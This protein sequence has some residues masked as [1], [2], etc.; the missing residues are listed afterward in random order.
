MP[1]P[2]PADFLLSSYSFELPETSIAQQPAAERG[3]SRLLVIDKATGATRHSHFSHIAEFLP[4]RALLVANNTRV[5]PARVLGKRPLTAHGG[6]GKIE[7]L[8]LTPPVLVEEAARNNQPHAGQCV[9]DAQILLKPAKS[10]HI[11][12]TLFFGAEKG[13][14]VEVLAKGEF[15]QA[16]ARLFWPAHLSLLDILSRIGQ[17]PLPPYIR[18]PDGPNAGDTE[19]YQ[20][21]YSKPEKAGSVAAPT[22][23]LHFAAGQKEN[24]IAQGFGWEEVTLHVGYGTFSPVRETDIR[25][26]AMHTEYVEISPSASSAIIKA[27]A[28]GRPIIAI[29]TTASRTLEGVAA[30]HNGTLPP[31][32]YTGGVNIFIYPGFTF[33][34]LDG[35]VTNFHLPESSLL[36]L[37]SALAGRHSILR[38][39]SEAIE[40]GYKFFS[41][42]DATLIT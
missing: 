34:V 15:G 9:A 33:R 16:D 36:M 27:K 11:G 17:I 23:G 10:V 12:E 38:A 32:G 41:Y 42:G 37:V 18:R 20:T 28:E 5:V 14:G 25:Q 40:Q 21:I 8:L 30:L 3:A 22:A 39:Y 13:L 26:H 2:I 35:M 29:G 4:P 6:G 19:R 24:L 31:N 1:A 7:M